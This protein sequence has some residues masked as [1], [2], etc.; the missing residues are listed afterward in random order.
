MMYINVNYCDVCALNRRA[1]APSANC[2]NIVFHC[3]FWFSEWRLQGS[4][5]RCASLQDIR[6]KNTM[7]LLANY[8]DKYIIIDY[9]LF[10]TTEGEINFRERESLDT[11]RAAAVLFTCTV[12]W[13]DIRSVII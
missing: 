10:M 4:R 7:K 2:I 3:A 12:D 8:I 13:R 6:T 11:F 9:K 5:D 1:F